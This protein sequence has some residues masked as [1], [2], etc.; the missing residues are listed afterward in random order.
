MAY[1]K[2]DTFSLNLIPSVIRRF[3]FSLPWQTKRN[4]EFSV[5]LSQCF[6]GKCVLTHFR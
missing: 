3:N 2:V 6:H 1:M 4:G 5:Q